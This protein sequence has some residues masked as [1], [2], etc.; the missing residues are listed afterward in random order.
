[1]SIAI[2]GVD[3]GKNFCSVVGVDAAGAVVVLRTIRRQTLIDYVEASGV[4]GR[5]GSMLRRA[6]S[7]TPVYGARPPDP[8][9]VAR[10]RSPIYQSAEER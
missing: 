10:I 8:V 7:G 1:M 9:D 6:S 5:N 2:L 3:L 4:C